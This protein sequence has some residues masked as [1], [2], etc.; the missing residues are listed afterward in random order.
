M[1]KFE[2][3]LTKL[4]KRKYI[5]KLQEKIVCVIRHTIEPVV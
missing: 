4:A 1:L 5:I 2:N 3:N